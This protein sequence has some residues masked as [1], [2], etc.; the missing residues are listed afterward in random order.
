[1]NVLRD[2]L[3]GVKDG[4]QDF[5]HTVTLCVNWILLFFVY[6]LGVG[7]T[8]LAAKISKKHFLET[9]LSKEKQTYWTDLNLTKKTI[10]DYYRQF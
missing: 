6:F 9:E 5:G 4:A 8:S 7:L 3:I 2:F 1:M 10:R